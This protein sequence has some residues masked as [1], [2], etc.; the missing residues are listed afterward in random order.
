MQKIKEELL[1]IK[2]IK[3]IF[4]ED[5]PKI[6]HGKLEYYDWDNV[7]GQSIR[8]QYG[9]LFDS[10]IILDSFKVENNRKVKISYK[11]IIKDMAVGDFLSGAIGKLVGTYSGDFYYNIGD[12]I[13]DDKRSLIITD[14]VF[15]ERIGSKGYKENI[16]HYKYTC[17]KCGWTEGNIEEYDLKEGRGCSCCSGDTLVEGINDIP[18]TAPW[19]IPYFKGGYDEAKLYSRRS[20]KRVVPICPD[21]GRIKSKSMTVDKIFSKHSI[22]CSCGDKTSYVE[23]FMFS[24]LEQ[25]RIDFVYQADISVLNWC[26]AYKY[27]FAI[28]NQQC[29]IETHGAQHYEDGF[30]KMGRRR[31]KDEQENDRQKEQLAKD[32][33]FINYIIV[34]SRNATLEWMKTNIMNSNLPKLLNFDEFDI[35][36]LRCHEFA[37]KN[38]IK[39]VC[40]YKKNYPELSTV[41]IGRVFK[42]S[43]NTIGNYLKKGNL[44]NWCHYNVEEE[45]IKRSFKAG[46]LAKARAKNITIFKD[47]INLGTFNSARELSIQSENLFGKKLHASS[48]LKVCNGK[49]KSHN[50]FTFN[51]I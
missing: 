44:L 7:I 33:K 8:F 16:K 12:K 25:L 36:W 34:N 30:E 42:I 19:M 14:Q 5:L 24:V 45:K 9:E 6:K 49:L 40:T 15:K 28:L 22:G 20:M 4:K 10:V 3:R 17:N 39:E 38:I 23:K 46:S 50:G 1:I 35:D 31:L 26:K 47:G 11:N 51:F 21:C 18:T 27:D 13:I 37:C 41:E 2:R 48:I 32:N 29:I 43:A